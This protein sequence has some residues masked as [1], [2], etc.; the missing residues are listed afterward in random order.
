MTWK[1]ETTWLGNFLCN[2]WWL[3]PIARWLADVLPA[4]WIIAEF[5]QMTP[6]EESA[7][8]RRLST[9]PKKERSDE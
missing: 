3:G 5:R 8:D 7:R 6:A 9:D 2:A 4:D 1:L